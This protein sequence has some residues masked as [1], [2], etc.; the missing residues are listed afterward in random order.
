MLGVC[1]SF[2]S[3]AIL[4]NGSALRAGR[5]FDTPPLGRAL[6]SAFSAVGLLLDLEGLETVRGALRRCRFT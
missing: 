3:V 2:A 5:I 1:L 4:G 6:Q